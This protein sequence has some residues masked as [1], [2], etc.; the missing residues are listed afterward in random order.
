MA[1]IFQ[2]DFRDFIQALSDN[3]VSYVLVG[4]F[5]VILYGHT[6]VTGDMPA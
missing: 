4:G 1:E 5:A 2:D 6:R 3:K